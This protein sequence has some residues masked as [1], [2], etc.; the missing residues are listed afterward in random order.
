[1]PLGMLVFGPIADVIT[2][3]VLF[4][5]SGVLMAIPGV[6]LFFNGRPPAAEEAPGSPNF[7]MKLEDCVE[8]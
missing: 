6:W 1:M 4:V 7:G 8:C 2:I 5:V 3:E